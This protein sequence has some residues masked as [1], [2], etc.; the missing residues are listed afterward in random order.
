MRVSI[1]G[2]PQN[3]PFSQE[4]QH[5]GELPYLSRPQVVGLDQRAHC[6]LQQGLQ[7]VT[8]KSWRAVALTCNH[9]VGGNKPLQ[10]SW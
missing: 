8:I 6:V 10:P 5:F 1:I 2:L 7:T 4:Y 9:I 3:H